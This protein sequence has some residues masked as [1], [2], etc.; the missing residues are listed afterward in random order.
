[1][2]PPDRRELVAGGFARFH[3]YTRPFADF[4]ALDH[5]NEAVC[6][7][8]HVLAEHQHPT[9]EILY[10]HAGVAVWTVAGRTWRVR[11]GEFF[12][13]HPGER[14]GG[15][16][17]PRRPH[18]DFAVGFDAAAIVP[19]GQ[20]RLIV[21]GDGE[22]AAALDE[23]VAVNDGLAAKRVIPGGHGAERIY[24]RILAELDGNRGEAQDP[25]RRALTMLAVQ[26]A[27]IELLVFVTRCALG[28]PA[29]RSVGRHDFSA[30]LA[31]METRLPAPPSLAEMAV[32]ADMSPS[33]FMTAFRRATGRTPLEA[34][35]RLR[36]AAAA[37][38]LGE[39]QSVTAVAHELGFSSSQYF[40]LVFR[41]VAGC[42]PSAWRQAAR[43]LP[44]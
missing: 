6:A 2:R 9:L 4:P 27:L 15:A 7:P 34:M 25:R 32:R 28:A 19:A 31:W 38:L 20:G 17:D 13:V 36:V 3:G 1:M 44:P 30:L 33:H 11:P 8:H 43:P 40:S 42:P 23:T 21:A 10:V 18:H 26:C 41:K 22:V 5:V 16:T 29:A 12:V 35:T 14:H 39:R 37:R 24:R